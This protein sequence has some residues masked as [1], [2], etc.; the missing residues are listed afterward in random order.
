VTFVDR[1]SRRSGRSGSRPRCK[2]TPRGC[3]DDEGAT[4]CHKLFSR[5]K[6]SYRYRTCWRRKYQNKKYK[7]HATMQAAP[8]LFTQ[9][10]KAMGFYLPPGPRKAQIAEQIAVLPVIA[11]GGGN[12]SRGSRREFNGLITGAWGQGEHEM[13]CRFDNASRALLHQQ[14]SASFSAPPSRPISCLCLPL[15]RCLPG[16]RRDRSSTPTTTCS[17]P[18][19]QA[20]LRYGMWSGHV[21][22]FCAT[23]TGH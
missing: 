1:S 13:E 17:H 3:E 21:K 19:V 4:E 20:N 14:V 18:S 23:P 15:L 22:S 9:K 5:Q 6:Q 7:G 16:R 11:L 2:G 8:T 10:G 12:I